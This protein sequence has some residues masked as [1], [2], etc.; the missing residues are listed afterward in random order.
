MGLGFFSL[1]ITI[2]L[3]CT[4]L[5]LL[6]YY[7]SP[8]VNWARLNILSLSM[9]L[10]LPIFDASFTLYNDMHLLFSGSDSIGP[11]PCRSLALVQLVDFS[12]GVAT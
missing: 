11:S 2:G 8:S 6:Q 7:N 12:C 3:L 9:P 10:S 5:S 1:V 4:A